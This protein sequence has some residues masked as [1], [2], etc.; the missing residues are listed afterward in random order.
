MPT[1]TVTSKTTQ[2]EVYRFDADEKTV[3]SNLP[4]SDYTYAEI[5]PPVADPA[6]PAA[7]R[8]V[9]KLQ[10]IDRLGD[11][12][13]LA[14]LTMAKQSIEVESWV[15]RLDLATPEADGTSIDLSDPRTVAGI[16]ALEPILMQQ[17][18]VDAGWADGVLN[19]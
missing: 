12:A 19:D 16:Q 1:F 13:H 6:P 15:K 2:A 14:V 17:G 9:T 3:W 8:R 5:S 18:I 4:E 10:F 7:P 11:S